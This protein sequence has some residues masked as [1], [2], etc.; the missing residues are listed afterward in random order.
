MQ[1]EAEGHSPVAICE[2]R[3]SERASDGWTDREKEAPLPAEPGVVRGQ[4][5]K[6][7]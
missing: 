6:A 7:L 5:N 3:G 2:W 4:W 1:R